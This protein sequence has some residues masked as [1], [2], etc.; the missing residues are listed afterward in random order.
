MA[1]GV[2]RGY[3][4]GML[5]SYEARNFR[6]VNPGRDTVRKGVGSHRYN[7]ADD[8]DAVQAVKTLFRGTFD[9]ALDQITVYE[10]REGEKDRLITFLEGDLA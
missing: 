2:A 3:L 7:A 4:R 9:P 8:V 10:L 1:L 6:L 5:R